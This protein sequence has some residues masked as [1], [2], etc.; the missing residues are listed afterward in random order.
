[1]KGPCNGSATINGKTYTPANDK[2]SN[3]IVV[4]K[5]GIVT[6]HGDTGGTV[7]TNAHGQVGIVVG[8]NT[9]RI[10]KWSTKNTDK[11]TSADGTYDIAK[12][13]DKIP[14]GL[15]GLYKVKATH[16]GT[17]GS[18][19]GTVMVKLKGNPL[20]TAPGATSAVL[21]VAAGGGLLAA[22]MGAKP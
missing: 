17:G 5:T 6:Y 10:E 8:G 21:T 13:I 4:P 2:K 20:T 1:M 15:V 3:A 16:T 11:K 7:I 12:G 19:S 9:V 22:A 18:C 14:G